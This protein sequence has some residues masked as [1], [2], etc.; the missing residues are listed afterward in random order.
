MYE[1]EGQDEMGESDVHVITCEILHIGLEA[2]LAARKEY[3]V[4]SDLNVYYNPLDPGAYVSPDVCVLVPAARLPDV[5]SSY[6]VGRDGPGPALTVEVLSRRSAQQQDTTNKPSIYAD[7][8]VK[9][10]VLVDVTGQFMPRRLLLKRLAPDGT[11]DNLQDQD[12]GVTSDLGFR[13]LIEDD[14]QVRVVD[15]ATGKRYVRPSEAQEQADAR[16]RAEEDRQRAEEALRRES[17]ARARLEEQLRE[18][19]AE[20]ERLRGNETGQTDGK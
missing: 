18:L 10:Y 12:G 8:G 14:G 4:F 11:W 9:E 6:K 16:Q 5:V 2:H 20:V 1:D 15:A 3:R 19:R 13:V 17:E 7:M